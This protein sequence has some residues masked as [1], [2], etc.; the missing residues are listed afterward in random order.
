[1]KVLKRWVLLPLSLSSA[2]GAGALWASGRVSELALVAA[3]VAPICVVGLV[4]L[5]LAAMVLRHGERTNVYPVVADGSLE[6]REVPTLRSA[7]DQAMPA[8]P[9]DPLFDEHLQP[10]SR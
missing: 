2:A 1:M 10:T 4:A 6:F 3:A 5:H 9:Q 7:I 8:F